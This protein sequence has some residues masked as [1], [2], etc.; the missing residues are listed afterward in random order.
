MTSENVARQAA[1]M[2]A[3]EVAGPDDAA[4]IVRSVSEAE[5]FGLL[6]DRHAAA[7]FRYAAR[8]LGPDV[9]DDVVADTFV[10]AFRQRHR[11]DPARQDSRPWLYGI[12][13]NLIARHRRS[14]T[15]FFRAIARMGADPAV[16]PVDDQVT[17]R[18][19]AHVVYRDVAAAIAA[20]PQGQRDVLLLTA[21]GLSYDEIAQ[22]LGIPPGT[23]SS[24]LVR[25]RTRVRASLGG[26]NPA[27]AGQE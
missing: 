11:Y 8:R 27:R 13:T 15:R 3:P 18:V 22:A 7:I 1:G 12:A 10:A 14:E 16:E 19:A 2:T 23:V 4:L 6:F 17:Q 25:A 24:R 26:G 21:S 9:A 20:L 5:C